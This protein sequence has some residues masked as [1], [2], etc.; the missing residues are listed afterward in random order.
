MAKKLLIVSLVMAI[1]TLCLQGFDLSGEYSTVEFRRGVRAYHQAEYEQAIIYFLKS[2]SYR[3]DNHNASVFLGMSYR[4]AGYDRNALFSWESLI[5][6]GYFDRALSNK[7]NY[8][9]LRRGILPEVNTDQNYLLRVD[10]RGYYEDDNNTPIFMRPT[11]IAIGPDNNYYIAS[12]LTGTVLQLNPNLEIVRNFTTLLPRI[13]R[14][15]GV[16]VRS[17]GKVYISD[18]QNDKVLLVNNLN[19]VEKEIGYKG[20]GE[21]ALLGPKYLLLDDDEN[22]FVA[23]SGNRRINKY[24]REGNFLF[25]FGNRNDYRLTSPSGMTYNNDQLYVCDRDTNKIVVFDRSGN[26]I[27]TF[28]NSLM[29][30][31][32]DLTIDQSGKYIVVCERKVIVYDPDFELWY[33]LDAVGNRLQRGSSIAVDKDKNIIVVDFNTSRMLVL[34]QER[35]RYMNMNLSIERVI[36]NDFPAVH[37]IFNVEKPDLSVPAGINENNLIIYENGYPVRNFALNNTAVKNTNTDIIIVYDNNSDFAQHR[38]SFRSLLDRWFRGINT[39][40]TRVS[41]VSCTGLDGILE[42]DFNDARLSF[43]DS[44]ENIELSTY[45]DK[46]AAFKLGVYSAIRRFSKKSVVI[47]TNGLETGRDF[48]RFKI[49]EVIGLARNNDIAVYIVNFGR[50]ELDSFYRNI[51]RETGGEYYNGYT[52]AVVADLFKD[53]EQRQG[54]EFVVSYNSRAVSRFGEEPIN[55][56]I[57]INYSGINGSDH[58]IYFPERFNFGE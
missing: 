50:G 58:T 26:H 28:E 36:S 30:K 33:E 48:N 4:K 7:I 23:D 37:V 42:N 57:D 19:L 22:L 54:R 38:N 2:L 12:F 9:N 13:E 18:Y 55:L 45:T 16:A 29:V 25:S 20:I 46:G 39:V 41:M 27:Q 53:I 8:I 47:V 3:H 51:A 32:Y 1:T 43:L 10:M 34:S 49:E 11:Q 52:S 44:V 15:Y 24:D 40:N 14:P 35:E 5:S 21:G 31:P 56:K 6:M 17:D